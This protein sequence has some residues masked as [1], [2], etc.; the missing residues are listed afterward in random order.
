MSYKFLGIDIAAAKFD[1]ALLGED[2]CYRQHTFPN[3]EPGFKALAGWLKQYATA[4]LQ[5]CLEATGSYGWALAQYLHD[6]GLKVSVVNPALSKAFAQSELQRTKTDAVDARTLAR[7][8]RAMQPPLWQPPTP[9]MAE[10][11]ALVRRLEELTTMHS[12]EACRLKAPSAS[13]FVQASRRKLLAY[14]SQAMAEVQRALKELFAR[15]PALEAQR[16]LLCS[17]PGIGEATAALLLAENA[18]SA[19]FQQARQLAAYAG[20]VP[21]LRQSGSSVRGKPRLSK[22]GNA[23]LRKALYWPAIVALR[24][25]PL[26]RDFAQRLQLNGKAKMLIIGAVMRKLLHQVFGVLKSQRP[27]DPNYMPLR[28]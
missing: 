5:A 17:I 26:L 8:C 12:Q 16:E 24:H 4:D 7:F 27:F 28:A 3:T 9:E 10:L 14:I 22:Q 6:A 23:R 19:T 2:D 18:A 11:Q 21:K 13:A 25:N 1:V 20:L 15:C